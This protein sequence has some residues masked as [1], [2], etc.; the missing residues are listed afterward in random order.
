MYNRQNRCPIT[1]RFSRIRNGYH[2]HAAEQLGTQMLDVATQLKKASG[3][4]KTPKYLVIEYKPLA[5]LQQ[6]LNW[7]K[8]VQR[9]V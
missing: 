8:G 7:V 3:T 4:R 2:D 5:A 1:G 9:S 6:K